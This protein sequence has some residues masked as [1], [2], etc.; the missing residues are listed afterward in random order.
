MKKSHLTL[1]IAALGLSLF[2]AEPARAQNVKE[3]MHSLLTPLR[4]LQPFIADQDEF[5][6]PA[7]KEK[8]GTLLQ[9]LRT[10]FHSLENIPSRYQK[11]P[12]FKENLTLMSDLLDDATRRFSEGR[13]SY[14]WWRAR[15]IPSSCFACH[16]TYKV[17]TTYANEGAIDPSLNNLERARFLLATRQFA[18][19]Q[20]ALLQVLKDP[21]FRFS[22]DEALRNLLIVVTR[23]NKS[24]NEGIALF[25]DVLATS[26]L[27]EEDAHEVRGWMQSLEKWRAGKAPTEK[28]PLAAGEKLVVAG[29]ARGLEYYQDD[30]SLL[31][32][33]AMIHDVLEKESVTPEQRRRGLYLL[34]F[35]YSSLPGYFA[36]SWAGMYLE[37]C[38][39]E[40]PGTKDAQRAYRVYRDMTAEEFTGS[41][42]IHLPDEVQLHLESLRQKAFGEPSFAG[43]V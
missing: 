39:N 5:S 6:D 10:N 35:A 20:E 7:N 36:E 14:A 43:R 15:G 33:T 42:G 17:S 11:V 13:V 24:P 32:G 22:Y 37:Q 18:Q 28:D 19:A 12:G 16:A 30:V 23:I 1:T 29:A 3:G 4:E 8:V 31:R 40:F 2:L 25:K 27:P 21:N 26:K 34:G 41:G 9:G 38:I